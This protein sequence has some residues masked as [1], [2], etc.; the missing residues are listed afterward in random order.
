[1]ALEQN[2]QGNYMRNR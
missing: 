2:S 1:L